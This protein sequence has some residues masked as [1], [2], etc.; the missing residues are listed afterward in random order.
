MPGRLRTDILRPGEEM[1]LVRRAYSLSHPILDPAGNLST[2]DPNQLIE[3]YVA[4]IRTL[5][6]PGSTSLTPRLF[7]LREGDRLFLGEKVV[8]HYTLDPVHG[9]EDVILLATGTGEAPHNYKVW[10][11]LRRGHQGR[12]VTVCCTRYRRDLAYLSVHEQLMR[13][14]PNYLHI[15]LTTREPDAPRMRL[16]TLLLGG[17]LERRMGK[18]L[19]PQRMHIFLCGNPG[20]IGAPRLNRETG[21]LE[22]SQ[23]GGV[24]EILV[25]RGFRCD[26]PRVHGNIHFEKYW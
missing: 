2:D 9:D 19:D 5:E 1:H 14:Y 16:Q 6:Q 26:Q 8:G 24:V 12:I 4:F 7:L 25:E 10:E 20:M 13:R 15:P 21:V 17:E 23:A 22:Y 3:F 18:P 11:L